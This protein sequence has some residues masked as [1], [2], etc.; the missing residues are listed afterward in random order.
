M[1]AS[2]VRAFCILARLARRMNRFAQRRVLL[3]SVPAAKENLSPLIQTC[4]FSLWQDDNELKGAVIWGL[5]HADIVKISK[6]EAS[7]L[8]GEHDLENLA[9]RLIVDF[10]IKLV[11][12]TDGANGCYL[13]NK[14]AHMYLPSLDVTPVDT[15]GA[16]D[17]FGGSALI[18]IFRIGKSPDDFTA[19]CISPNLRPLRQGF[20]QS[21]TVA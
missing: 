3:L 9:R 12:L 18:Q 1:N 17:I 21:D 8:L 16:G 20:L 5:K 4:V 7:F 2:I 14:K 11:L 19:C 6:D 10:K 15:I 13:Q